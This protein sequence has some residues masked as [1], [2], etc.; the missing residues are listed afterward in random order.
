M[1]SSPT[2]KTHCLALAAFSAALF[3]PMMGRGFILDD[4]GH[5]YVAA[6][7]SVRF[8]L[9]RASGGPFYAP[10]AWFTFKINWLLWGAR[11]FLWAV[12]NLLIHIA[13]ILLLYFL[14][15]RLWRSHMA[16]WWAALGFAL[17]FPAN[18]GAIMFISTRAH[19]VSALF[20][21]ATMIATLSFIRTERFKARAAFAV[22]TFAAL[23]MFAK[24]SGVTVIAAV[25]VVI[26]YE[27]I[28]GQRVRLPAAIALFAVLLAV[29]AFYLA[30]RS[31]SGA[32]P[33]SFSANTTYRYLLSAG[34]VCDNLLMY[35]GR[36][37]GLLSLVAVAV[38]V[39][40]HLR[41]V[42]PRLA[43][44][45]RYDVLFS[46]MLFAVA[47]AP[48]I[49]IRKRPEVYS[50]L[51]GISASLLLGAFARALYETSSEARRR[52]APVMLAPVI[53]VIVSYA[54][55]TVAY[56]LK[57][58]QLAETNTSVLSQITAQHPTVEPNTFI[59]L[60][61]SETD[62][63]NRFPEGFS[64]WC[65]PWALRVLYLDRTIDGKIIRQGESYSIG[66][67]L[68]E[69]RFSYVSGD[70]PRVVKTGEAVPH[71]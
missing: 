53:L 13:N 7:D 55:L 15:L 32:F 56:S 20:Y 26:L 30:L 25:G 64:Y 8:G 36:T 52:L 18:I 16:A 12:T 3:V 41:G 11:P 17:L 28:Q 29:L 21:L 31:Q 6:F 35:S 70:R 33:V 24:E 43:S 54:G 65:F 63:V 67:K 68:S 1:I 61:Y 60:T 69:V 51:P 50:Y 22:I 40:L 71:R 44:L 2:I 47:I 62:D 39:S 42:H 46:L 5:A 57:W 27:R 45:T 49:L 38:A 66:N 23:S 10:V 9:M 58:I 4:F 37:Y 34:V 19:L 48:F 59:V 14:V